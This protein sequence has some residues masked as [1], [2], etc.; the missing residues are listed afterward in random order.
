MKLETT[1]VSLENIVSETARYKAEGFRFVTMTAVDK[2]EN[3]VDILYHFD[4]DLSIHH[5]ALE[6]PKEGKTPSVSSVFF[7]AFLV[8]NEIAEQ[9]GVKFD[10]LVLDFD[11]TMLLEEE[12]R[13]TPFC[14]YGIK[15]REPKTT[16]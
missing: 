9:F 11:G 6:A 4:K 7:T 10:G 14:K 1:S 2:D 3:T 13:S 15:T 16:A 5:L 12:V 8:E